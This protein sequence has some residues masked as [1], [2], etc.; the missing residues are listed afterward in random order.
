MLELWDVPL[1]YH[2]FIFPFQVGGTDWQVML[3][4]KGSINWYNML[5]TIPYNLKAEQAWNIYREKASFGKQCIIFIVTQQTCRARFFP[6]QERVSIIVGEIIDLNC[7][8]A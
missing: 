6:Q 7:G 1:I 5:V 3:F 8:E 2:R 4:K